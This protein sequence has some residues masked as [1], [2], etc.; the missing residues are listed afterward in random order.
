M[1]YVA[2]RSSNI[3]AI[4]YDDEGRVLGVRFLN[5]RDYRYHRVGRPV[6][7]GFLGAGSKGGYFNDFVK[8]AYACTRVR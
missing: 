6:Y 8:E 1:D 2:V 4:A 3:A 5:G 7:L